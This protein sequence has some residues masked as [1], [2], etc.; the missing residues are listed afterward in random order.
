M[1]PY[2]RGPA[3][4]L[5]AMLVLGGA[6]VIVAY[7]PSTA[8]SR[9]FGGA[10]HARNAAASPYP[11][12][13]G[14]SFVYALSE[15]DTVAYP[16]AS[17]TVTTSTDTETAL[18]TCP[19]TF[20]GVAGLCD[21]QFSYASEPQ[22]FLDAYYGYAP[23]GNQ[24]D[25]VDYGVNQVSTDGSYLTND[26]YTFAPYQIFVQFPEAPGHHFDLY[27]NLYKDAST[28]TGPNG[29]RST[30]TTTDDRFGA[31]REVAKTSYPH[32]VK[33]TVTLDV[34]RNA[35]ARYELDQTGYNPL[36]RSFGVPISISGQEMIPVTTAGGNALPATPSPATTAYVADWFPGGGAPP[37]RLDAFPSR[38][39]G[40]VTVPSPCGS[41]AGTQAEEFRG[42]DS[43][44]DPLLGYYESGEYDVFMVDGT[45]DVCDLRS[46]TTLVFDNLA[47]GRL[48]YTSS[49]ARA[50][51]LVG[52]NQPGAARHRNVQ[53]SLLS[54]SAFG[55]GMSDVRRH[56]VDAS[57]RGRR[58]L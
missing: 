52:E 39:L 53:R 57:L 23:V 10:I 15:T 37:Q 12:G 35:S 41:Y 19:V 45:G 7:G 51:V 30:S 8:A 50:V 58:S 54:L 27:D 33:S 49:V 28:T 48:L 21:F 32:H 40:K 25:F 3:R 44:L 42:L 11:F 55:A 1:A 14:D 13:N 9:P 36:T 4:A 20:N 2:K 38:D 24:T 43:D 16:S 26:T 31:Y 18:E 34:K 46:Y 47:T 29:Y 5:A 56:L 17:P 6:L 22:A